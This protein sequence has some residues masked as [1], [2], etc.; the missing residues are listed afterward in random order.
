MLS[1]VKQDWYERHKRLIEFYM[2]AKCWDGIDHESFAAW[3]GNFPDDE[4]RY[5]AL[6]LLN[7]FIFYSEKDVV[8]LCRHGLF[9]L[10]LKREVLNNQAAS[11]FSKS[12]VQL[13]ADLQMALMSSRI[14]PLLDRDKPYE[15]GNLIT[16]ILVQKL[17]INGELIINPDQ[18]VYEIKQGCERIIV[19]DDCVGSGDQINGF[20]NKVYKFTGSNCIS[21]KD[22]SDNY[23]KVNF[24]Y[25]T[26]VATEAGIVNALEENSGINILSCEVLNDNYRVFSQTSHFFES[27]SEKEKAKNYL[28]SLLLQRGVALMGY[29]GLD[30]AIAFHHNIPDWSLPLFYKRRPNWRPLMI[31]KDSD[32]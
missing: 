17:A 18:V 32:A 20:W 12:E 1:Q 15:S 14:V 21:F 25:L 30:F 9:S 29:G 4:G 22:V 19:V 6:R 16:R 27:D 2:E 11:N 3:L 23:D 10:L 26:L 31:R 28:N 7:R 24:Y 13:N 8:Q 5:Y